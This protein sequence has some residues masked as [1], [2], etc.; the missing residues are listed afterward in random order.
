L[1]GARAALRGAIAAAVLSAAPGARA[2]GERRELDPAPAAEPIV[3]GDAA[4]R[5]AAPAGEG[6][7]VLLNAAARLGHLGAIYKLRRVLDARGLLR[8]LPDGLAAALD[9]RDLLIADLTEIRDAYTEARF[10]R[11]LELVEENQARILRSAS[12]DPLPALA[13]LA[14]WRALIAVGRDDKAG[15]EAWFRTALRLNPAWTLDATLASPKVARI[16]AR[17]RREAA[18]RGELLVET[19]PAGAAVQINGGKRRPR[20]SRIE[21]PIGWHLVTVTAPGRA[22]HAE[23]VEVRARESARVA[24]SLAQESTRDRAARLADATAAVPS[25]EARL[26]KVRSVARVIGAT[27]FLVVE[28]TSPEHTLVRVYDLDL[29]RVSQPIALRGDASSAAIAREVLA[30]LHPSA[31]GGEGALVIDREARGQRRWYQRWYLWV[32]AA[33]VAGGGALV[34]RQATREPT[35]IRGF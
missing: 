17:A 31:P 4:R 7:V 20:G 19:T 22:S 16:V 23:L 28:D 1:T 11:A 10:A 18:E 24:V 3:Q 8:A 35:M 25:G 33:A 13:Q 29:R 34:Y 27:R 14:Q 2:D 12:A 6:Q 26:N 30:A 15:A 21:L 9:G 32:G 5:E